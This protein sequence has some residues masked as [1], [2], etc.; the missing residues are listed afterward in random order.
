MK[1]E[2]TTID[3]IWKIGTSFCEFNYIL[4]KMNQ[5]L[6]NLQFSVIHISLHLD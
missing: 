6:T 5:L 2:R 3:N 1:N 4:L